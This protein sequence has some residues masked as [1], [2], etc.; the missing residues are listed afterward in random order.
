LLRALVY[1]VIFTCIIFS[2]ALSPAAARGEDEDDVARSLGL[3]A[4]DPN[5]SS[6]FPRP[7]SK[8][9]EDVTVVTADD[10][11]RINAHT[12]ADVLQTVPG[13]QLDEVTSPG[14]FSFFSVLGTTTKHVQLLIDG[15]PQ[16]LLSTDNLVDPGT[17]PV[18]MIDRVEIIKGA[19]SAAYGSA[20]GGV[21]NVFTKSPMRERKGAGLLSASLGER[22]TSDS[23]VELSGTTG[24]LGYFVTGGVLH[25]QGLFPGNGATLMHG[26]GK[27]SYDLPGRGNVT[28][29]L[30]ARD[31]SQGQG[32]FPKY[33][34]TG[35]GDIDNLSGSLTISYPVRDR[36]SFQLQGYGGRHRMSAR[37][38]ALAEDTVYLDAAS[39]EV[40]RGA[41][42]GITWGDAER[43]VTAGFDFERVDIRQT[44]LVSRLPDFNYTASFER[45]GAYLNGTYS[46][47]RLSILPGVRLD[48]SNL[49]E[50][51]FSYTLGGTLRLTDSTI[52][53]AYAAR[54]Y[55]VPDITNVQV[56]NGH[57]Q[58]Q[59]VETVQ[60]GLESAAI[61][62][63]WLKA[64]YFYNNIWNIEKQSGHIG[65]VTI[66]LAEQVRKGFD[67]E[68]R[69]S[70]VYGVALSAGYTY[71]DSRDK[72]TGAELTG[73]TGPRESLKL[74]IN[75][76]NRRLGTRGAL[77]GNH[78]YWNL[79]GYDAKTSA[80]IW[81]LHLTQKLF[82]R[83]ELSP[84]LF[85]SVHNIFNDDQYQFDLRP[86]TPRWVEGGL[87]YRF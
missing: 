63:L 7:A 58:L 57:R 79:P 16:N 44:E 17:I 83:E 65:N 13:V 80:I 61:P 45:W 18:Q 28:L 21:I 39:R 71:S 40:F 54:G 84:E 62:F 27:V 69:T 9:A 43:N 41:K 6:R 82:P 81:D 36:L 23:R 25:T 77:L 29:T 10:I 67:T 42:G 85:F 31:N 35:T 1:I 47:G 8:I 3:A 38:G 4:D 76:D 75:Y 64:T 68:L 60:A 46:I 74:G 5:T 52:V 24:S 70:P 50:D 66:T 12:L 55:S 59:N 22:S 56:V 87:R 19:A 33:D 78:V 15:V 26:L 2:A 48:Q 72:K 86:N 34:F 37:Q 11:A 20:L 53:R 30:D 14:T 32:S 73:D 49:L 51:A